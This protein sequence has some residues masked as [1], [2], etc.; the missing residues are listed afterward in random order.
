MPFGSRREREKPETKFDA[1]YIRGHKMF[2]KSK[3]IRILIFPDVIEVE[4]L[5][6]KVP[7]RSFINIENIDES[8]KRNHPYTV[9]NYKDELNE[10]QT[11]VLDFEKNVEKAQKI[12][13][14]KMITFRSTQIESPDLEQLPKEQSAAGTCC[15][16]C[17]KTNPEG[18]KFCI[19]CGSRLEAPCIKCGTVNPAGSAFCGK[20]GVI[21]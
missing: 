5:Q 18:A 9:I 7:Y 16:Q 11:L 3:D 8:K 10:Y 17:G 6:L 4:K 14:E 20:C 15:K 12:I 1:K 2:P 13:Y 19:N 21:L